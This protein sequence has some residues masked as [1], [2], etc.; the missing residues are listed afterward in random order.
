MRRSSAA[1]QS[2][3][4]EQRSEAE[5]KHCESEPARS[6]AKVAGRGD[7]GEGKARRRWTARGGGEEGGR[8]GRDAERES[9]A[10]RAKRSRRRR[11]ERPRPQR[12]AVATVRR[13][14]AKPHEDRASKR[15]QP[16]ED[17]RRGERSEAVHGAR[18]RRAKRSRASSNA[19]GRGERSEAEAPTRAGR[20]SPTNATTLVRQEL[21]PWG[22]WGARPP[23]MIR[24]RDR[25]A[26]SASTRRSSG[27]AGNRTR[28]LCRLSRASPCAVHC[29]STRPRRSREQAGVTG[30]A[31]V[32]VPPCV[33]GQP[34]AV[35]LLADAG[36]PGRRR[37]RADRHHARLGSEGDVALGIN[38]GAYWFAATLEVAIRLHLHASP[39]ATSRVETVHP[40][41]VG[42][43]TPG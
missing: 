23:S 31:A 27:G 2:R 40:L 14:E 21:A 37:P 1:R 7:S 41:V 5:A 35:S 11:G 20:W 42:T 24:K 43:S 39:E 30:P 29:A 25:R 13:S 36:E 3:E 22:V 8:Q 4:A 38:L 34:A 16:A 15:N 18:A 19:R 17:K 9:E 28:V 32:N 12:A 6:E 33:R 10:Q 26:L